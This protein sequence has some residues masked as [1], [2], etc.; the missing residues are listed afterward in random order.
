MFSQTIK[1]NKELFSNFI[2]LS[3]INIL[4]I[5]IPLVTMPY[6]SRVL[7]SNG[8][9]VF[10]MYTSVVSLAIIISDYSSNIYGVREAAENKTSNRLN[11]VYVG[12]QSSRLIFSALSILFGWIY[13]SLFIPEFTS[14]ISFAI[15]FTSLVG[16]FFTATWFHQGVSDL[17]FL[18]ISSFIAR[19]AQL[20]AIFYFIRSPEDLLLCVIMNSSVYFIIGV[21][22]RWHR[23]DKYEISDR[24]SFRDG[25]SYTVKGFNSFI[26]DF[27]PNLYSN[28]PPLII[29][30]FTSPA[31]FASYA[32]AMRIVNIAGSF[33]LM[34][35]KA[36][37]PLIVRKK[38]SFMVM[39]ALSFAISLVPV[40]II[41]LSGEKIVNFV[42]GDGYS[43]SFIYLSFLA[44]SIVFNAILCSFSYGY[45]L[46]NK[47]D[48]SFRKISVFVSVVSA[49]VGYW[50]ISLYGALGAI[51]MFVMARFLFALIYSS[52]YIRSEV[53]KPAL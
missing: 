36:A 34:F 12:M 28:I 18:A 53:L 31:T 49:L 22:M 38:I 11:S 35:A 50:M 43:Q 9:G 40:I 10:F 21:M 26:G 5:I 1:K 41:Y 29:G 27:S 2:S 25:W 24:I 48:T 42:F 6:L 44:P 17:R 32:I 23:L 15:I 30:S 33:Q 52:F 16:Y 45:L 3:S 14:F 20:L 51:G 4:N 8:Y 37:Y 46:P 7:G 39:L 19:V 13:C 47:K